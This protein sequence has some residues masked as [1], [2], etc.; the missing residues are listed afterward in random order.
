MRSAAA[1]AILPRFFLSGVAQMRIGMPSAPPSRHSKSPAAMATRYDDIFGVGE[2]VMVCTARDGPGRSAV[3]R[4]FEITVSPR[5]AVTVTE[6]VA[7]NAGS[8]KQGNARRA[9]VDSNCVT[10]YD[11]LAVLLTYKPRRL[12]L[13]VAS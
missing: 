12:S 5:S 3:M 2:K 13:S 7:L 6:N 8:S 11:R 10:A 9:S 1:S 4:P